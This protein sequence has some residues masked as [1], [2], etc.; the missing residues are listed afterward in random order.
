M[1]LMLTDLGIASAT[2]LKELPVPVQAYILRE[3]V[4]MGITDPWQTVSSNEGIDF[5]FPDLEDGDLNSDGKQDYAAYL[6]MFGDSTPQFFTNGNPC[7]SGSLI[8]SDGEGYSFLP[9][10]G[11]VARASASSPPVVVILSTTV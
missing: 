8:V 2:S 11:L 3:A 1:M 5:S 10:R 6:C 4:E 7:A 9:V